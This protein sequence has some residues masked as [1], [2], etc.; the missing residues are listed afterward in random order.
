MAGHRDIGEVAVERE[1]GQH[2]HPVDGRALRLVN[3]R[4]IAVV[5]MGIEALVDLDLPGVLPLANSRRTSPAADS[6][7]R[8]IMPFLTPSDPSFLRKT[9]WSP[10]AKLRRPS[11]VRKAWPVPDKAALDELGSRHLVQH[12]G[13]RGGDGRGSGSTSSDHSR[14]SSRRSAPSTASALKARGCSLPLAW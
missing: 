1:R 14:G 12:R 5:D 7:T 2:L 3:G 13:R 11:S 8:A 6:T 9:I 10:A 4:G